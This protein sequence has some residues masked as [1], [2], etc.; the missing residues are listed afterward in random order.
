MLILIVVRFSLEQQALLFDNILF[1][2]RQLLWSNYLLLLILRGKLLN[3][4][5]CPVEYYKLQILINA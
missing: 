2:L 1:R 3:S 5:A 4:F